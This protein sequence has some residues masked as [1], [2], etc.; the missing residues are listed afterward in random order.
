MGTNERDVG[1]KPQRNSKL[2]GV[3]NTHKQQV[4]YVAVGEAT[5]N[6]A[7]GD[8][9]ETTE[10]TWIKNESNT[11]WKKEIAIVQ[12]YNPPPPPQKKKGGGG[13]WGEEGNSKIL[14]SW[15]LGA[16]GKYWLPHG[17]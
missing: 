14:S 17:T 7:L 13:E 2:E 16:F 11:K 1:R 6:Y 4:T 9:T 12:I 5:I 15:F 10:S 8:R 3:R